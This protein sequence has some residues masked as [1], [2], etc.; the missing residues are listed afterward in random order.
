MI[1]Y[2]LLVMKEIKLKE[3]TL[4]GNKCFEKRALKSTFHEDPRIKLLCLDMELLLGGDQGG[5]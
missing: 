5:R 3:Y 4:K 2:N 1:V